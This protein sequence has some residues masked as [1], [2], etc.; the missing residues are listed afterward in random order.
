MHM[1]CGASFRLQA[2]SRSASRVIMREGWARRH[3]GIGG[4]GRSSVHPIRGVPRYSRPSRSHQPFSKASTAAG[5]GPEVIS[6]HHGTASTSDASPVSDAPRQATSGLAEATR[7]PGTA[8]TA[9]SVSM[10]TESPAQ[11]PLSGI[12][13]MVQGQMMAA[14]GVDANALR[15][16]LEDNRSRLSRGFAPLPTSMPPG[17]DTLGTLNMRA[18]EICLGYASPCLMEQFTPKIFRRG[19]HVCRSYYDACPSLLLAPVSQKT[20]LISA[21]KKACRCS[22]SLSKYRQ[23]RS[24]SPENEM[25]ARKRRAKISGMNSLPGQM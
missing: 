9:P 20:K 14:Q 6:E 21:L 7:P 3:G 25:H 18:L 16:M 12:R 4:A 24:G 8:S 5:T 17:T 11:T 15:K 19:L 22:L 23:E 13:D 10:S 1:S 2:D